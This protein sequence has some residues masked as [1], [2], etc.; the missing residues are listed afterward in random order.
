VLEKHHFRLGLTRFETD[1]RCIVAAGDFQMD[2]RIKIE[3]HSGVG[4]LRF[5][6]WL[7]TIGFLELN[8]WTGLLGIIVWPYFLGSHFA[9]MGAL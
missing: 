7:F 4:M 8:F 3:Q 9:G 1:F 5:V 2:R 6:G